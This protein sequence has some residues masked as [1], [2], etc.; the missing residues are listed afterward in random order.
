LRI[1]Y[2]ANLDRLF[3]KGYLPTNQDVLHAR[4]K[5]DGITKTQLCRNETDYY[6]FDVAGTRSDRKKWIH[7][8]GAVDCLVFVVALGAFDSCLIEDMTA[9]SKH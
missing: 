5:T 7:A 8:F 9:V 4:R 2:L 6:V 3:S 1:S